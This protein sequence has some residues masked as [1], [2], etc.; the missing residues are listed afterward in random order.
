MERS[1]FSTNNEFRFDEFIFRR[2]K[3]YGSRYYLHRVKKGNV[4]CKF[5]HCLKR[6]CCFLKSARG[7]FSNQQLRFRHVNKK[8]TLVRRYSKFSDAARLYTT[9]LWLGKVFG[10]FQKLTEI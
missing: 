7:Q 9:F 6:F 10:Y 5:S 4:L 3:S 2:W 1:R 8:R